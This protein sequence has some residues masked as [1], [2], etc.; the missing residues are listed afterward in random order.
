MEEEDLGN[1]QFSRVLSTS[2]GRRLVVEWVPVS[3]NGVGYWERGQQPLGQTGG[4][5]GISLYK[6][7]P[8]LGSSS[9]YRLL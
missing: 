9:A 6:R 2:T 5:S 3:K 1:V 4:S 8:Y 7:L